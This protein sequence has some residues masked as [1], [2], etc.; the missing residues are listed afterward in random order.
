[1]QGHKLVFEFMQKENRPYSAQDV[2]NALNG[3]I[4][5]TNV[6]NVLEDLAK[7]KKIT[8]KVYGKQKVYMLIQVNIT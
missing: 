5:K 1:M 3:Q 2:T 6:I 4:T 7:K 8:E